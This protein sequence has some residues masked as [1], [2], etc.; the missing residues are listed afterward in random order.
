[1]TV[2]IEIDH[3]DRAYRAEVMTIDRTTLGFED[4]GIMTAYLHCSA[5]SIGCTLGGYFIRN[6]FGADFLG[7][8]LETLKAH[9]WEE[10]KGKRI[11][12]LFDG[13]SPWGSQSIG[14]ANIDTG[15]VLIFADFWEKAKAEENP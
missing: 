12:V 14:L 8:I 15:D 2:K 4:H 9:T 1:M 6:R 3:E 10:L 13:E 11:Y 5:G 7:T